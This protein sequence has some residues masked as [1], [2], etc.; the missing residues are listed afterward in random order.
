MGPARV[1]EPRHARPAPDGG[2]RTGRPY[3]AVPTFV[4]DEIEAKVAARLERQKLLSRRPLPNVSFV[5]EM[6]V[7]T[8][9]IGG[10]R[11]MKAQLHHLAA[12]ARL[13]H[14]RIQ[15]MDP[16]RE[17]HAA[18]DGPFVLLETD[19]D[20]SSP[21]SRGRAA[22][23]SR[24]RSPGPSPPTAA[25]RAATASKWPPA[26]TPSTSATPRTS[27]SPRSPSPPPPGRP[28]W[29]SPPPEHVP[30][31]RRREW[32][33]GPGS[34]RTR[35]RSGRWGW[36]SRP[37]THGRWPSSWAGRPSTCPRRDW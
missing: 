36:G 35:S 34:R 19:N 30:E 20:S 15:M 12:V 4:D 3:G 25:A 32:A 26:P 22:T 8:R 6:V 33:P 17:D 7:L 24:S 37:R 2:V 13:R 27:P 16:Y 10:R 1:R 28:S 9:P 23:A 18:L 5:L 11:V 29:S 21:I 14:V 31:V